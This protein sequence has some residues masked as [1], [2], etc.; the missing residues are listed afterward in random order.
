MNKWILS[1]TLLA[2]GGGAH[3]G[4]GSFVDTFTHLGD[5]IKGGLSTALE[6]TENLGKQLAQKTTKIA[7]QAT[8][9][10]NRD[11]HKATR[12][13]QKVG[14]NVGRTVG[15]GLVKAPKVLA[16]GAVTAI[17]RT[18]QGFTMAR[19]LLVNKMHLPPQLVDLS[20]LGIYKNMVDAVHDAVHSGSLR[21]F[22]K[23]RGEAVQK[24]IREMT[25][26]DVPAKGTHQGGESK[27]D[28]EGQ[29][30]M[31]LLEPSATVVHGLY[32]SSN[33]NLRA[34]VRQLVDAELHRNG[35]KD[36]RK[37]F[38]DLLNRSLH[39]NPNTVSKT[40]ETFFTDGTEGNAMNLA[41]ML[42]ILSESQEVMNNHAP[43]CSFAAEHVL[44][45]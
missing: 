8:R 38:E 27:E 42:Y 33:P 22:L 44:G 23:K 1:V 34:Q 25:F 6:S 18:D 26:A 17:D 36:V 39:E 11:L 7:N 43:V 30:A 21:E 19:N 2:F 37:A 4:Y 15:K 20:L 10:L 31:S 24:G 14:Q 3:Y 29:M 28:M 41:V 45:A 16:R 32:C 12:D 35:G 9:D 13:I 40:I 5:D